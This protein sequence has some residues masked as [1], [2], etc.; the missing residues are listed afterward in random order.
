M[1]TVS[2]KVPRRIWLMTAL[3]LACSMVNVASGAEYP[4]PTEGDYVIKDFH[5]HSGETM[6]E[7]KI[8]YRTLGQPRHDQQ[9]VVHNAV[10]IMHGTTGSGK[11]FLV[12]EF[13]GELFGP[14]QLLDAERFYIVL[15][16]D[17]GHGASSKPSD[18]EHAKFPQYGYADMVEAEH[19][20]VTEGLKVNHLR[21]VMGTSM[22]GMHTWLWGE[23]YPNDMD[24]LMPLASLPAQIGGR[25]RM[26]RRIISE[27]TRSD[28]EWKDGEYA[29]QPRS[30]HSAAEVMFF[31]SSN[32]LARYKQSPTPAQADKL[33]DDYAAAFVKT[34]DANDV[35]YAIESSSDYDPV[36]G[37]GKI[38]RT[39]FGN[40]F[41][42]R[43]D[44]P[45]GLGHSQARNPAR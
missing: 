7:L 29:A 42:R 3:A 23:Q 19:R 35:L 44:Q 25:N 10:L 43:S 1:N 5:F 11:Q 34:H 39:A 36:P 28:P 6:P 9:D 8:H 40:K 45:S 33:L 12:D 15:P 24:A 18:G 17:I 32:P 30:L 37:L 41:R 31:M 22:G 26:W 21:L 2:R 14:G 20:L 4:K 38:R 27:M 13:A 16:D